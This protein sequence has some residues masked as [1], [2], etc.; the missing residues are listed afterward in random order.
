MGRSYLQIIGTRPVNTTVN[1]NVKHKV[2]L[3]TA[4]KLNKDPA[5]TD[6]MTNPSRR[7]MATRNPFVNSREELQ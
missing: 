2:Y 5:N 3:G 7:I 6:P 4:R 1:G